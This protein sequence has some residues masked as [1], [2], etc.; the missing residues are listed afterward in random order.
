MKDYSDI[1]NEWFYGQ[2]FD[3]PRD[4]VESIKDMMYEAYKLGL[5]EC[6]GQMLMNNSNQDP[7]DHCDGDCSDCSECNM[8]NR[9][10]GL[11]SDIC[12]N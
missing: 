8:E 4:M 12:C 10:I 6:A 7:L 5:E 9:P 1:F 11:E 3:L 2:G